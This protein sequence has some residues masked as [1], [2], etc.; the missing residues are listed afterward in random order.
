L[1]PLGISDSVAPVVVGALPG[2]AVGPFD[3]RSPQA[4]AI[5]RLFEGTLLICGAVFLL[6]AV[7]VFLCVLR[8]RAE[9]EREPRQ[10]EGNTR[11]EIAWTMAPVLVLASLLVLT[12]QAMNVSDPPVHRDPD[13]TIV[14][15]QWWWEAKYPSG[16]VAA[17]EI[18]IPTGK[19]LVVRLESADVVHD[20]WVPELGRKMDAT[21]GRPTSL[22]IEADRPGTYTGACA[23]YCGPQHAW[24]RIV[25]VAQA[26]A[27]FA[28]WEHHELG[29]P[30]IAKDDAAVR[31]AT[32]FNAM[33]CVKC[34]SIGGG[35]D[36]ARFA[37]D[38]THFAERTTL[39]AGVLT[40]TPADLSRWLA[41]PQAIK[42][43]CHMP[44]AQ[45]TDA[46]V[47]DFVAYL[48]TLR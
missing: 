23:E 35:G 21:P 37:P 13:V 10:V 1:P 39:G 6:V 20:F 44:N 42:Q 28:E 38:L 7:L 5:A 2:I 3:P 29:P 8:F 32:L 14:G 26:P 40:N 12:A 4:R 31:G 46:Q 17:N 18:H 45:L 11:L 47:K 34:H 36:G 22:W 16:V 30:P 48:E 27:E 19:A 15:H 33:T 25:V 43:G 9:D 41:D 24:M